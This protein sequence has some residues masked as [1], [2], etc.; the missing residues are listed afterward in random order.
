MEQD[1][2]SKY[3]EQNTYNITYSSYLHFYLGIRNLRTTY[4]FAC[5]SKQITERYKNSLSEYSQGIQDALF[6]RKSKSKKKRI[7]L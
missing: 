2:L 7:I 5:L 3:T 6:L 4:L 1:L